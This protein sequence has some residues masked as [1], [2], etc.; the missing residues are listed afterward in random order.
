M[1]FSESVGLLFRI[2]SDASQA[3]DEIS[4]FRKTVDTELSA[5]KSK[6]K[7]AFTDFA[8]G[9]GVSAE[10]TALLS[11]ALPIAG[12]G[13]A[14]FTATVVSAGAAMFGLAK[15]FSDYGSQIKD[16]SDK[17]G[18]GAESVSTLKLAADQAGSS[19]E[20]VSGSVTKFSKTIGGAAEG[21]KKDTATLVRLGLDPKKAIDDLDA[22]L[23]TVFRRIYEAKNPIVATKLATEAFG[24]SGADLIPVIKQMDGDFAA[25]KKRAEE[26]GVVLSED[27]VNAA[28]NFGDQLTELQTVARSVAN[29]FAKEFTP[30]ITNAMG[31]VEKLLVA[32]KGAF[33][34]W[35][36]YVGDIIR[37]VSTPDIQLPTPP[38][39]NGDGLFGA[40]PSWFPSD[41]KIINYIIDSSSTGGIARTLSGE[42]AAKRG[43]DLRERA[44]A[45]A[46]YADENVFA[47]ISNTFGKTTKKIKS[48]ADDLNNGVESAGKKTKTAL[49]SFDKQFR[50]FAKDIDFTVT[51]T[52]RKKVYNEGSLH[53]PTDPHAGDLSIKGKTTE[54][55]VG[56]LAAGIEKG[57]RALDERFIGALKGINSTAPNLHF[58]KGRGIKPSLFI[59]NRPDLYGGQDALDYLKKLDQD[60]RNKRTSTDDVKKFAEQR[61]AELEKQAKEEDQNREKRIRAIEDENKRVNQLSAAQ[62]ETELTEL[63]SKLAQKLIKESEYATK[64]G[65]IKL[66]QLTLEKEQNAKLLANPDL[67][68]DEKRDL[69]LEDKI[70]DEK[71]TQQKTENADRTRIAVKKVNDEYKA[72]I[73]LLNDLKRQVL[74]SE[75][76]ALNFGKDQERKVLEN[77]LDHSYG[78]ERINALVVL[79][80]FEI[81][82]ANRR[83]DAQIEELKLDQ[84][85]DIAKLKGLENEKEKV[86]EIN[87]LYDNRREI[88]TDTAKAQNEGTN[89]SYDSEISTESINSS[90]I[91]GIFAKGLG[92][93]VGGGVDPTRQISDQAE[94]VKAVYGDLKDTAAGAIGSM[95][96]GL[97][98]M[99]VAW[100]TTGKFSA[101]AALQ[102][103]SSILAS[104][105]IQS[106]IKALF[107]L[108][109][110][111]AAAAV[112]NVPSATAHF[113][114]AGIFG[115][116]AA[117][118]GGAAVVSGLA[119]RAFGGKTSAASSSFKSQT[120]T[121]AYSQSGSGTN[122][123]GEK[124]GSGTPG[125]Y[126]SSE[127]ELRFL[128]EDRLRREPQK[129]V[130]ELHL[131]SND[132]HIVSTV[133]NNLN[134][135]GDL[136]GTILKVVE[137]S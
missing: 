131:K 71:I 93:L 87:K 29:T 128:E 5:I 102:M 86:E 101:K 108:A 88:I 63:D 22:S 43:K 52:A 10:K 54:E 122:S 89:K 40:R 67:N 15:S 8:E 97:G 68:A 16:I 32:N 82:E 83:R 50:S 2:N 55:I 61:K 132:S 26:L 37:G 59:E 21:S 115:T 78:K 69:Q 136:R 110:G 45:Q 6:G 60:R 73:A 1:A 13:I 105:A 135:Y 41:E 124:Q 133:Q 130:I 72:Q 91:A 65:E 104:I 46:Q 116:V 49:D 84:E 56:A 75:N 17:T 85:A 99:A 24:K 123:N 48:A 58:E 42:N 90:G 12:A 19:I 127:K 57:W 77:T 125:G 106:G 36:Q 9:L 121:G 111:Y 33:K 76:N 126:Y 113:A 14:G 3:K 79:R 18:L 117:I 94:Y 103:T 119:S 44:E 35:G 38:K 96:Q 114:A 109:E 134:S 27:D 47:G 4:S 25:F 81:A 129:Q 66:R 64:V 74:E 107:E 92:D 120:A 31:E 137:V 11:A 23:E 53:T 51:S 80:S 28:D 62:S 39:K 95:V 70:L 112:F 20:A 34:E 100:L 7:N 98:Q 30:D 118:A